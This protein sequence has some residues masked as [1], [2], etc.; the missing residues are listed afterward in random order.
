MSRL[1]TIA[2]SLL[3]PAPGAATDEETFAP[4]RFS[5]SRRAIVSVSDCTCGCFSVYC[6][7][8]W[9]RCALKRAIWPSIGLP[10][11]DPIRPNVGSSPPTAVRVRRAGSASA[12]TTGAAVARLRL[13][14][15]ALVIVS[16]GSGQGPDVALLER[17]EPVL[18]LEQLALVVLE[19]RFEEA[20]RPGR[21]CTFQT[22]TVLH[23]RVQQCANDLL[24]N[25]RIR[26]IE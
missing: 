9:S 26:I 10:S 4:P 14:L 13:G 20:L 6:S 8:N 15:E 21:I 22:Q 12:C 5:S 25:D 3:R 7:S 2:S 18:R 24:S 19:L 1:R 17:R 16:R 23:E 11:A